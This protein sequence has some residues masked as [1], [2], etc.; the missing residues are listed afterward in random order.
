MPFVQEAGG[1]YD[2]AE[3]ATEVRNRRPL[4]KSIS[5]RQGDGP[6]KP[7]GVGDEGAVD[8]GAIRGQ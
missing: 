5:V 1:E 2:I 8:R 6:K 3:E 4:L 7:D